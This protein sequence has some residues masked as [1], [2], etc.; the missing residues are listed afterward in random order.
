MNSNLFAANISEFCRGFISAE[1]FSAFVS[2]C[3]RNYVLIR[4]F[5]TIVRNGILMEFKNKFT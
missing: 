1:L 2:L 5:I 3:L 4:I